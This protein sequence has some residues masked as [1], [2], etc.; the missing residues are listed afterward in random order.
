V[1]AYKRKIGKEKLASTPL[2]KSDDSIQR[3]T[4]LNTHQISL[5]NTNMQVEKERALP[6]KFF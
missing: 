3:I 4:T 6:V 5:N 2:R 1:V